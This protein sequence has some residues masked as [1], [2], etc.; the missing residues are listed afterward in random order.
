MGAA[1]ASVLCVLFVWLDDFIWD[2]TCDSYSPPCERP[3]HSGLRLSSGFTFLRDL[4]VRSCFMFVNRPQRRGRGAA[5]AQPSSDSS[6][7]DDDGAAINQPLAPQPVAGHHSD[8]DAGQAPVAG[9]AA[10]LAAPAGELRRAPRL[11]NLNNIHLG[12][13]PP[14]PAAPAQAPAAARVRARPRAPLAAPNMVWARGNLFAPPAGLNE[15][16]GLRPRPNLL[17]NPNLLAPQVQAP[18]LG[19]AAAPGFG[20][21]LNHLVLPQQQQPQPGLG[22]GAAPGGV[23]GG[24]MLVGGL[25]L[26]PPQQPNVNVAQLAADVAGHL[27]DME[28]PI[29]RRRRPVQRNRVNADDYDYS[30]SPSSSSSSSS[31]SSE[32]ESESDSHN[33]RRNKRH[34]RKTSKRNYKKLPTHGQVFTGPDGR[35]NRSATMRQEN[36]HD[37]HGGVMKLKKH[38]SDGERRQSDPRSTL[39]RVRKDLSGVLKKIYDQARDLVLGH[40]LGWQHVDALKNSVTLSHKERSIIA[41]FATIR[42]PPSGNF[43]GRGFSRPVGRRQPF[44]LTQGFAPPSGFAPNGMAVGQPPAFANQQPLMM[45]PAPAAPP[46]AMPQAPAAN[47]NI[48]NNNVNGPHQQGPRHCYKC[49]MQGH[50]ARDCPN[51]P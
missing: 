9:P 10:P 32:S 13:I 36:L 14:A 42:P 3:L 34:R 5:A 45:A 41:A 47:N 37:I 29:A 28:P 51:R 39:K 49:G 44:T 46:A 22:M 50:F 7:D 4:L 26:L 11:A 21:P 2:Q 27:R 35:P 16:D 38:I 1:I 48:N 19:A 17:N 15:L 20:P 6:D 33:R 40:N 24:G 43:G 8:P 23:N 12:A 31:S 30:S 25:N 18:G